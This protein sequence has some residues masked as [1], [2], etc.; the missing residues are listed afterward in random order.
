MDRIA[1]RPALQVQLRNQGKDK[2]LNVY[3]CLNLDVPGITHCN[4][5]PTNQL[6]INKYLMNIY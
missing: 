4:T 1:C 5:I 3:I 2:I 6:R